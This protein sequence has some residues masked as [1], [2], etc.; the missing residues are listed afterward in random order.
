MI[1][2]CISVFCLCFFLMSYSQ[3]QCNPVPVDINLEDMTT[4]VQIGEEIQLFLNSKYTYDAMFITLAQ[5]DSDFSIKRIYFTIDNKWKYF[6]IDNNSRIESVYEDKELY[7]LFELIDNVSYVRDCNLCFDCPNKLLLIKSK[8]KV[9]K[10]SSFLDIYDFK[11]N[12]TVM[13]S[14]GLYDF[15]FKLP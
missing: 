5:G 12:V 9:F 4:N 1:S 10:Y 3:K 2:K 11:S 13:N 7:R 6:K 8:W 15:I 14:K